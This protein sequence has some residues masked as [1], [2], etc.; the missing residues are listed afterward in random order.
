[1]DL[2]QWLM[3]ASLGLASAS[4][5]AQSLES[6]YRSA[7]Q[8]DTELSAALSNARATETLVTQGRSE[9][10]PRLTADGEASSAYQRQGSGFPGADDDGT[11]THSGEAGLTLTQNLFNMQAI[12]GYD[13]VRSQAAQSEAE[14]V[15]ARADLLVR[16]V[17]AYLDVLR[18]REGVTLANRVIETVERQLEQTQERYDVG[19]VAITDVLEATAGLDQARADRLEAENQLTLARQQLTRITGVEVDSLPRLDTAFDPTSVDIMELSEWMGRSR[20]NPNIVAG[21]LGIRAA[22]EE[23]RANESDRL[24]VIQARAS[25]G[26]NASYQDDRT[27]TQAGVTVP[28]DDF[29]DSGTFRIALVASMSVPLFDG[30]A[31]SA[32]LSRSGY[33]L[34]AQEARLDG[35]V[36][37]I[38]LAVRQGYQQLQADLSRLNALQQVVSSRESA[39]EATELGY[40]VG[41]RN[42]VEVLNAQQNLLN[43]QTDLS[44]A[45]HSFI[46]NYFQLKEAAGDL[47]DQDIEWLN[48]LLVRQ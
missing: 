23:L 37:Q 24:P 25:Y 10:L 4:L 40:E 1:M 5:Q 19:L 13:A 43:A 8:N 28:I 47:S 17:D 12:A 42:V 48:S 46:S 31:R 15:A 35:S 11:L 45:R 33:Q 2:R 22:E 26:Y 29:Q 7:L 38:E 18:A 32:G 44:N 34:E 9:L 21:R 39:A 3:A 20:N 36:R 16:V 6:L 30:G 14:V 41:S 27:A